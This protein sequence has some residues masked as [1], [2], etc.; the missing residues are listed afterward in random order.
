MNKRKILLG[1]TGSVASVLYEKL[2]KELNGIGDVTTIL[3]PR[4][5]HFVSDH[6][7]GVK[8]V[9]DKQEWRWFHPNKEVSTPLH[10]WNKD[11]YYDSKWEK[12]DPIF[13]IN[14]R[15]NA[16][17]L[18]IAPCSANTLAK[19]ANGMADN[20][21]T[22]VAR[23]WDFSRPFI[24]A[25]SMNTHMY[26]HPVTQEHITKLQS[27]GVIVVPPQSKMLACNT[28]GMG[29][30]ANI[31]EIVKVL[32]NKLRWHFPLAEPLPMWSSAWSESNCSGIPITGHQGSF[33]HKRK[34]HTHTGVDLYTKDGQTVYAMES[35]IVVGIEDFTG[36]K[37]N[38]PWWEDTQCVLIEGAS[39]VICYGEITPFHSL[40][41]G[42]KVEKGQYIGN[43][44]RVL[45]E[46]K[47]RPDIQGHS[48]SMLHIEMYKHGIKR[49]FEEQGDN[50]S[51][52]ND[53]IDPTQYLI[54]SLHAPTI[55][56]KGN[57]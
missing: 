14:L 44:K 50:L 48:L 41:V 53:L 9:R 15:D 33:L 10:I 13:H 52:W 51:D 3:T 54:E 12:N 32:Q 24:V 42:T 40:K 47:E 29:A 56:L 57:V 30:M 11:D 7:N 39:G 8:V 46:G 25:P 16:S 38:M 31:D 1:L 5:E 21:L 23:A 6:F 26:F 49:A 18:V 28:E 45:K 2:I 22:S 43:V 27:W 55:L 35:G 20:L 19:L 17:A 37:Q 4:A 34:M 36:I